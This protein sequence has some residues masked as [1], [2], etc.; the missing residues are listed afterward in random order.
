M[1]LKTLKRFT[2]LPKPPKHGYTVLLV[3]L[4]MLMVL[5]P[6]GRQFGL[7]DYT[8][9]ILV[10][11]VLLSG[12]YAVSRRKGMIGVVALFGLAAFMVHWLVFVN[13]WDKLA[14]FGAEITGMLFFG[15]IGFML[16]QDIL[17]RRGNV[18]WS[19]ING[20]LSVYLIMGIVFA[21]AYSFLYTITP[22]AFSGADKIDGPGFQ[23]FI[24]LSYVTLTTLG[25]G[26]IT[27]T[28][29][30]ASSLITLEAVVGQIYLTVLVARLV[31]MHI[32][33]EVSELDD[34]DE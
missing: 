22:D 10:S 20:A 27:P 19:L 7:G 25:F 26:D 15:L 28:R 17:S 31:G 16:L 13:V 4:M 1:A 6:V 18:S 5:G 8:N 14:L 23:N 30:I 9:T 32:T 2:R 12:L 21:F 33:A 34:P 29:P 3:T 11:M 24:Y